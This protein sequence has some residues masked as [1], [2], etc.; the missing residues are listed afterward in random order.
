MRP[1]LYAVALYAGTKTLY[2]VLNTENAV[3]QL[4]S[5]TQLNLIKP[6]GKKSGNNFDKVA[7]LNKKNLITTWGNHAVLKDSAALIHLQKLSSIN[8]G[9]H[10][11]FL[12]QADK[13]KVWQDE[14][15]LMFQD[16]IK[17]GIIL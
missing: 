9:D 15:I 2:N 5:T 10:T 11:T 13:Y 3:L 14:H 16:L 4:L 6:L 12:F 17:A 8:T 7:Y 1:K